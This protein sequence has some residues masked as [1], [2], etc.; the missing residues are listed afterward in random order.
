MSWYGVRPGEACSL[1]VHSGKVETWLVI[2]GSGRAQVGRTTHEVT[3]GD[4]LVT[5]P[6]TPHGLTNTGAEELVFVN[7]VL[8]TGGAI[9]TT[10]VEAAAP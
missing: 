3:A 7:L 9:T 8:P 6:G 5:P 1:H 4:V 2:A 10:E